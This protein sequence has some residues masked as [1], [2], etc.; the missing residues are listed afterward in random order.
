MLFNCVHERS[1]KEYIKRIKKNMEANFDSSWAQR[2]L[3]RI[4]KSSCS[5]DHDHGRGVSASIRN[6]WPGTTI[7][8][9]THR[10]KS[11]IFI[12]CI[13]CRQIITSTKATGARGLLI[14]LIWLRVETR[15][16]LHSNIMKLLESFYLLLQIKKKK[17]HSKE[18]RKT[19]M[20]RYH[21]E[22]NGARTTDA[23]GFVITSI[24]SGSDPAA[25]IQMGA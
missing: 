18:A 16:R 9:R 22:W 13:F 11:I 8:T 21:D 19:N 10:E 25:D 7:Q 20:R 3:A 2:H 6:R 5:S 17:Q 14:S 15:I 4:W 12:T 24:G 23:N 1:R